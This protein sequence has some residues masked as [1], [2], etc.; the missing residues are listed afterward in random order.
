MSVSKKTTGKYQPDLQNLKPGDVLH[1]RSRDWY[2]FN[3]LS[4][5]VAV[6]HQ[7]FIFNDRMAKHCGREVEV[8]FTDTSGQ[9]IHL[10]GIPGLVWSRWM[11]DEFPD[12]LASTQNSQNGYHKITSAFQIDPKDML[13]QF[14]GD[15]KPHPVEI[16]RLKLTDEWED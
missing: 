11:F 5:I 3:Q 1:I 9:R 10:K 8:N 12:P 7:E 6:P 2:D 15:P 13:I 16:T 4:G 14:P